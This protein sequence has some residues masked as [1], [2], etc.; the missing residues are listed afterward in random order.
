MSRK[1]KHT[2]T[3]DAFPTNTG[4]LTRPARFNLRLTCQTRAR[5]HAVLSKFRRI[6]RMKPVA[7]YADVWETKCLPTLEHVIRKVEQGDRATAAFFKTLAEPLPREDH[8]REV[9]KRLKA[10]FEP[11][12]KLEV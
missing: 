7:N 2:Y 8:L 10:K 1:P 6:F 4:S 9:Y 3:D 11:Q 12:M 5:T